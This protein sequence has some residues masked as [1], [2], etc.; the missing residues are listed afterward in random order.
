M[1]NWKSTEWL[2]VSKQCKLGAQTRHGD[3]IMNYYIY[4]YIYI[5]NLNIFIGILLNLFCYISSDLLDLCFSVS[6]TLVEPVS[7]VVPGHLI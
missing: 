3:T 2:Q 4:I 7:L 1:L 5:Y 6:L